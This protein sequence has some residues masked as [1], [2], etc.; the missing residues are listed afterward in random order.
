MKV[1]SFVNLRKGAKI[2]KQHVIHMRNRYTALLHY[3]CCQEHEDKH[4]YLPVFG[5]PIASCHQGLAHTLRTPV[6]SL[7]RV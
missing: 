5:E 7:V 2:F 6:R 4:H 3:P 1:G